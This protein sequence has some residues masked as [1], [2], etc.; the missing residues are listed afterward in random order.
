MVRINDFILLSL[1]GGVG[2]CGSAA[3]ESNLCH[4]PPYQQ[5]LPD[6]NMAGYAVRDNATARHLERR[7]LAMKPKAGPGQAQLWPDKT[8]SYC[9]ASQYDRDKL[10]AP[11]LQAVQEWRS[12]GLDHTFTFN[13]AA[14]PGQCGK[15][16]SKL[17]VISYNT[18]GKLGTTVGFQSLDPGKP[19]YKGPSMLL[20]DNTDVGMLN[21]VANYAHEIGHAWGLFHE[22]QN[23]WFWDADSF[24]TSAGSGAF[25]GRNFNCKALK[26]YEAAVQ[27]VRNDPELTPADRDFTIQAICIFRNVAGAYGFSAADWLPILSPDVV[28]GDGIGP[29]SGVEK[30]DRRSIMMYPS[31]AGGKGDAHAGAN[32]QPPVDNREHVLTYNDGTVMTPQLSPS[33][34]DVDGIKRIYGDSNF[35]QG[36]PV[37]PCDQSSS[38]R[39]TFQRLFRRG[40]PDCS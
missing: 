30:V 1:L 21:V 28:Y 9:F 18:E 2:H 34:G 7:Y 40:K 26:D 5:P 20:S 16:R 36:D 31:G 3:W 29:G 22:H 32:G 24:H 25:F 33:Q 17:L 14:G 37:L 39:S 13:E 11:F 10:V 12:A 35:P 27:R 6:V 8:I 23:R 4:K 15:Q 19:D 38:K